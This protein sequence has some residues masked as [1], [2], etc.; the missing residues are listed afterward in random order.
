[1]ANLG[2]DQLLEIFCSACM[3]AVFSKTTTIT[4]TGSDAFEVVLTHD[5]MIHLFQTEWVLTAFCIFMAA[6]TTAA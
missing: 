5:L 4:L 2:P 3:R 1:M 6:L